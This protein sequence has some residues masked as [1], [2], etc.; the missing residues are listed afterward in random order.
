M[1][2]KGSLNI[3]SSYT[4]NTDLKLWYI[5]QTYN[6]VIFQAWLNLL[7]K[8]NI[9]QNIL[10]LPCAKL[11][12]YKL[13]CNNDFIY[14]ASI[15]RQFSLIASALVTAIFTGLLR[16]RNTNAMLS[17]SE[18]VVRRPENYN[19]TNKQQLKK[20]Q[21]ST[22]WKGWSWIKSWIRGR[23]SIKNITGLSCKIWKW[24]LY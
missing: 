11:G 16:S 2:S 13:F 10:C 20:C 14:R 4:K 1:W 15:I 8:D 19:Q 6:P 5:I 17:E 3:K 9:G 21:C 18:S 12:K 7:C 22:N 23:K 24:T